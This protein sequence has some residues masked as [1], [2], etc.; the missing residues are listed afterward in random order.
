MKGK[1]PTLRLPLQYVFVVGH[2]GE[3]WGVLSGLLE[4]CRGVTL[5]SHRYF[6]CWSFVDELEV[7]W[8]GWSWVVESTI[9]IGPWGPLLVVCQRFLTTFTTSTTVARLSLQCQ[10][11]PNIV[12]SETYGKAPTVRLRY[13]K[14][15]PVFCC[16]YSVTFLIRKLCYSP[17]FFSHIWAW[18]QNP[19]ISQASPTTHP[20]SPQ[21]RLQTSLSVDWL[22]NI[23]KPSFTNKV[24]RVDVD[25]RPYL[26]ITNLSMWVINYK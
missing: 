22:P 11:W 2:I 4:A 15:Y 1:C 12:L 26:F 5:A 9:R 6:R 25:V 21:Y 13:I 23:G 8:V 10:R 14:F 16:S 3:T 24:A 20:T 18:R 17:I 7:F 19:S